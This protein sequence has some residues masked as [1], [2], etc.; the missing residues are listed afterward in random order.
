MQENTKNKIKVF[1][2]SIL[3]AEL[4]GGLSAL[5]TRKGM[6]AFKIINKPS[7]TPPAVVFPIVWTILFALMGI[8]FGMIL[9]SKPSVAK[10]RS[11][12]IYVL[13]LIV[14]FFWSIFFF[15]LQ[16]FGLS[17]FWLLLLLFLICLM[18]YNFYQVNKLS[19]LLQIP[20]LIWVAFA[21]YLTFSIWILN[22]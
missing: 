14:N 21:G 4:I 10:N 9:L 6:E 15:N 20:Y 12:I 1:L 18:I 11:I 3:S 2:F 22:K 17:F 13:Q 8:S 16:A 7:L 19:A 5:L